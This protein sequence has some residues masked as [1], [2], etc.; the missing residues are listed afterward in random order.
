MYGVNFRYL[1]RNSDGSIMMLL[2]CDDSYFCDG[3]PVATD[4]VDNGKFKIPG[5]D[6]LRKW[7]ELFE[8]IGLDVGKLSFGSLLPV[9]AIAAGIKNIFV[10]DA[11]GALVLAG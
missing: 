1:F 4:D 11:V 5:V 6:G 9:G 7:Y 2:S 3:D 8:G 10:G